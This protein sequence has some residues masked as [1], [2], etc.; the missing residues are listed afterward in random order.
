MRKLNLG[1]GDA[2][3][4]G[5]ENLDI[6]PG[7]INCNL[8]DGLPQYENES[9]DGVVM[10]HTLCLL[11][12]KKRLLDDIY[13]VLKSGGFFRIVDN[14]TRFYEKEPP[15]DKD[16][17]RG[18]MSRK[19]LKDYLKKIGFKEVVETERKQTFLEDKSVLIAES[20]SHPGFA[21]EMKK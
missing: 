8:E 18:Y 4:D 9:I 17:D 7:T 5:Y 20:A 15:I 1:A 10:V 11:F 19:E 16:F 14:T 13:R 21:L 12:N 6:C 2:L 3:I